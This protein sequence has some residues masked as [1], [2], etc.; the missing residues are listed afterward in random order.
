MNPLL[1]NYSRNTIDR[2]E[3]RFEKLYGDQSPKLINRIRM[4]VGRYGVG[5]R[6]EGEALAWSP[7]DAVLITY[8]DMVKKD[9]EVPLRTLSHVIESEIGD[10]VNTVHLLPF[11]PYSS[12]DGFSVIDYREVDPALGSWDDI[13]TFARYRLMFD[14][15][16]NHISSRSSWFR[17]FML[18]IQP[19][20][21]YFHELD[22]STDLSAVTRPRTSPLLTRV[23]TRDG[24]RH[25]WTT[26][27]ADQVDL[28]YSDP[29]VFFDMLDVLFVYISQ[30]A[31]IIRMDAIAYLWK[32]IGTSCIHLPQTHEIVKTIRE[33]LKM[34]AP[35]VILL[36]E[37]NVPH[38]ENISY[39]GDG[40]EAHMVY[41]F[42]LP[43]LLLHGLIQGTARHLTQWSS[44]LGQIPEGCTYLNFTASHDGIGV[45]PLE[46]L[47]SSEDRDHLVQHVRNL[48]G[49][50]STKSNPDGSESPYELNITYFDALGNP[51]EPF[52]SNQHIQR[53]LCS[54]T[55]ALGLQGVP[56]IY[57]N[58]LFGA[59]NNYAWKRDTGR[60]RT[61]NR[62]KWNQQEL[63]TMLHDPQT[64]Y[65][66][67]MQEYLRRLNIRKQQPAFHPFASQTVHDLCP[68]VF[69]FDRLAPDQSQRILCLHNL[70][71]QG[72]KIRI[73]D[74]IP[75]LKTNACHNLLQGKDRG[76]PDGNIRLKAYECC[77]LQID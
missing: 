22:P 44:T 47:I 70:S 28:N 64:H 45:R 43:P 54:Q 36:T 34:I 23:A 41:Q 76:A 50:V 19:F 4:M 73:K 38:E 56:A 16:L 51:G 7:Q 31:R 35:E 3:Q 5:V 40:D 60:A 58:S 62:G 39:F 68:G 74:A 6:K 26:F 17:N 67:V 57:F 10:A 33:I 9:G 15:V 30:G 11:Y 72:Q 20:D 46:G 13:K 14:L 29:E 8:G 1:F 55:V 24:D 63:E 21:T 53:F 49:E 12:D 27:S 37:T 61:I 65:A 32:E 18:G 25:V 75:S 77:W 69:A 52:P 2:I 42:S 48:G 71:T 59:R 66:K